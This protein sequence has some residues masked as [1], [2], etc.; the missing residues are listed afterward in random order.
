MAMVGQV[1][2]EFKQKRE[3]NIPFSLTDMPCHP[4]LSYTQ[5]EDNTDKIQRNILS[6]SSW[7][8]WVLKEHKG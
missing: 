2:P 7:I 3:G 4:S 8:L 1:F 5:D 6:M